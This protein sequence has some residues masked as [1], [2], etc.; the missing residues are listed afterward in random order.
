MAPAGNIGADAAIFEAV[1]GSAPDIAG[2]GK[3]NP[4]ALVLSAAMMLDHVG[5]Q[6]RAR[7]IRT[8]I[9]NVLRNDRVLTGDLGG[10]ASTLEFT[11]AIIAR[12]KG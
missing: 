2:Q 12:V 5:H 7:R 8:A 9:D 6:D 4:L 10:R 11:Q 3:A 1:H